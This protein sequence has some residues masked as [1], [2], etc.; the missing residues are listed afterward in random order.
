MA[1]NMSSECHCGEHISLGLEDGGGNESKNMNFN[2]N[3]CLWNTGSKMMQ[4]LS[5]HQIC[6]TNILKQHA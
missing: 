2:D 6:I 5:M 3:L 1:V 4:A